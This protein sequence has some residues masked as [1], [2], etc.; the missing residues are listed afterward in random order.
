MTQPSADM[1]LGRQITETYDTLTSHVY[2]DPASLAKLIAHEPV[3]RRRRKLQLTAAAASLVVLVAGSVAGV[4]ALT[5]NRDEASVSTAS[6]TQVAYPPSKYFVAAVRP[7]RTTIFRTSDDKIAYEM[8]LSLIHAQLSPNGHRVFG[9]F[10]GADRGESTANNCPSAGQV[11]APCWPEVPESIQRLVAHDSDIHIGYLDLTT[12]HFTTLASF[13]GYTPR[14]G[15]NGEAISLDGSTV[16]Y[17]TQAD[18]DD[19]PV[20]LHVVRVANGE[21]KSYPVPPAADQI[22]GMALSPDG[23]QLAFHENGTSNVYLTD[24]SGGDPL[25]SARPLTVAAACTA[26]GADYFD[27]PVWNAQGLFVQQQCGGDART[28][29]ANVVRIDP[30]TGQVASTVAQLPAGGADEIDLGETPRGPRVLFM[31]A[32]GS[33]HHIN[34]LYEV[35]PDGSFRPLHGRSYDATG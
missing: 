28:L 3:L 27:N 14:V 5:R 12:N 24:L 2:G 11:Y 9:Y 13:P 10:Y 33:D 22:V 8:S 26:D 18:Q 6:G 29:T 16:A 19:G 25:A 32:T 20:T 30:V 17:T 31:P 35:T 15:I 21:T 34:T 4:S 7:D 1:R 23:H